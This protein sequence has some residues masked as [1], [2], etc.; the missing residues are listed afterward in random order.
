MGQ[1][2][3]YTGVSTEKSHQE[4][5]SGRKDKSMKANN[6]SKLISLMEAFI[7]PLAG[8]VLQLLLYLVMGVDLKDVS[9]VFM[10]VFWVVVSALTA[11]SFERLEVRQ[12][13]H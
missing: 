2:F 4:D 13:R 10:I 6:R 9:L 12:G 3:F 1:L 11:M 5:R 8:L 7:S